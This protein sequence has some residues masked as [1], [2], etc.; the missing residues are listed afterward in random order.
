MDLVPSRPEI[1]GL[2]KVI[3]RL[4]PNMGTDRAELGGHRV[5]VYNISRSYLVC[6]NL[7]IQRGDILHCTAK[8]F[9]ASRTF[10]HQIFV[11]DWYFIDNCLKGFLR[12]YFSFLCSGV[13]GL[14]EHIN[15]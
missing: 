14:F 1:N 8:F 6:L 5:I 9:K 7:F 13:Y 11:Q 4:L 12:L 10:I 3:V 2:I 15:L